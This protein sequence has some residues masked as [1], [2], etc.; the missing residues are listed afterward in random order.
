MIKGKESKQK[1]Y[2]EAQL[3]RLMNL[4]EGVTE[5]IYEGDK[6]FDEMARMIEEMADPFHPLRLRTDAINY[7]KSAI[8][9]IERL[10]K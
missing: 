4:Y 10:K 6:V 5:Q 3:I 1:K 2:T 8:R 9:D 7:Y